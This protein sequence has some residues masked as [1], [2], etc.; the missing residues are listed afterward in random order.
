MQ[1]LII[2]H[3]VVAIAVLVDIAQGASRVIY[4]HL[5][6]RLIA[7]LGY[8]QILAAVDGNPFPAYS[9]WRPAG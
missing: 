6:Y 5:D 7:A 4:W 2:W 3:V 1:E 8:P 9:S